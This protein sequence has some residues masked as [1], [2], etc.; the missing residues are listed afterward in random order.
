[1]WDRNPPVHGIPVAAPSGASC[2]PR[3]P[4]GPA[5]PSVPRPRAWPSAGAAALTPPKRFRLAPGVLKPRAAAGTGCTRWL[6]RGDEPRWVRAALQGRAML[7][8]GQH[9]THLTSSLSF[10]PPGFRRWL[11]SAAAAPRVCVVGSGPAGFYTAQHILK[12]PGWGLA[13]GEGRI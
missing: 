4:P 12:V 6:R 1:M 11:C 13:V 3:S 5:P 10:P 7:G 8:W 2:H 9:L